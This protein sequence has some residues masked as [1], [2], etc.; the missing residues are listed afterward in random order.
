MPTGPVSYK[1]QIAPIRESQGHY[2]E[3][4]KLRQGL[5][6]AGDDDLNV[7]KI[8][9][10]NSYVR[11]GDFELA[12]P[13]LEAA[14][15]SIGTKYG[16]ASPAIEPALRMRLLLSALVRD[17]N[18]SQT[19]RERLKKISKQDEGPEQFLPLTGRV[20]QE[21]ARGFRVKNGSITME[22][23]VRTYV[24]RTGAPLY[25]VKETSVQPGSLMG[26]GV[27]VVITVDIDGKVLEATAETDNP[28]IK[29]KAERDV[30]QW[31][32]APLKLNG[33]PKQMRGLVYYWIY[34]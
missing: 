29:N 3:A 28:K 30:K 13:L 16:N 26:V 18:L 33:E 11:T 24:T 10:A 20:N 17:N 14:V 9:L 2:L 27:P 12:F 21:N 23:S 1:D 31:T 6:E 4:I 19:L 34:N 5:F 7:W 15:Q 8:V 25:S 22:T 32:L